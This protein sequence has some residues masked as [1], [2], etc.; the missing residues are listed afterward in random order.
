MGGSERQIVGKTINDL[1]NTQ[2]TNRNINLFRYELL[3]HFHHQFKRKQN[4][5]TTNF[6][7]GYA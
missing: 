2:Y 3:K 4:A 5:V 6:I 7:W 1:D